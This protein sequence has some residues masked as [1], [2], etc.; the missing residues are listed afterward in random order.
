MIGRI[1][2]KSNGHQTI[3]RVRATDKALVIR[4]FNVMHHFLIL[5]TP[6]FHSFSRGTANSNEF[7]ISIDKTGS[8][9]ITQVGGGQYELLLR[10]QGNEIKEIIQSR[11]TVRRRVS[12]STESHKLSILRYSQ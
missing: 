7:G 6:Y 5:H 10:L 11:T 12:R 1:G 8:V 9:R 2:C 3:R 4:R